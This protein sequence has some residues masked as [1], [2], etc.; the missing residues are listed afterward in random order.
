M[1]L[2]E[3]LSHFMVDIETF[4]VEAGSAIVSIGAVQ[5][6][7]NAVYEDSFYKTISLKDNVDHGFVM[8]PETVCWWMTQPEE[9]RGE[10]T[11]GTDGISGTLHEFAIWLNMASAKKPIAIWGNGAS[12]D[13]P[14]LEHAYTKLGIECPW[15]FWHNRCFRTLKNGY[16]HILPP[17]F[18]G[19]VH[20]ALDDAKNQAAHAIE[21]F[22]Q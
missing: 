22:S 10:V 3:N 8:N 9:V 5:F 17:P 19:N 14:I 21:I 1:I 11:K 2:E 16:P 6:D 20:H 15:N 12:F 13:N 18:K 4:G 7:S